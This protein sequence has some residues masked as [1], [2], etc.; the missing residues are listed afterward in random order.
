M[1]VQSVQT[2]YSSSEIV[3]Y[4][5]LAIASVGLLIL[6]INWLKE[7]KSVQISYNEEYNKVYD[8]RENKFSSTQSRAIFWIACTI[9]VVLWAIGTFVR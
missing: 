9:A 4:F 2:S 6:L 3:L 1:P 8:N 5:V 7:K